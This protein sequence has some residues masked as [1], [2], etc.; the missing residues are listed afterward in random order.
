MS[1]DTLVI[2]TPYDLVGGAEVVRA[3]VDRFYD[4]MESDPA[5]AEL[6]ALHAPDLLPMR[7][8]L[9]GFLV[10]WLGGPRD[11]FTDNPGKCMMSV[12]KPIRIDGTTAAQWAEAM[13]RAIAAS[14][15]EPDL[16]GKMAD[17]LA[18]LA[19]NMGRSRAA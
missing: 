10:A 19:L 4:E 12:H 16:G 15:V 8:S 17:A 2:Q 6:R 5:F 1:D 3:I 9:A 14:P 13:R 7:I 11:W 18:D